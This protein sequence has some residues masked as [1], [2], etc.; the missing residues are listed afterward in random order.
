MINSKLSYL[1]FI[2]ALFLAELSYAGAKNDENIRQALAS[3]NLDQLI[4]VLNEIKSSVYQG[5]VLPLI[6]TLWKRDKVA[7]PNIHWDM[8]EYDIVRINLAD[9]LVQ[10]RNNGLID[11]EIDD[12]H[13][14]A[15]SMLDSKDSAVVSSA[16]MVLAQIDDKNDV[17]KI[18]KIALSRPGYLFRSSILSLSMMCNS[19]AALALEAIERNLTKSDE[20]T[21]LLETRAKFA[22]HKDAGTYCTHDKE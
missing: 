22:K 15:V 2:F 21:F 9:I 18:K 13:K 5:D 16:V 4:T 12:L 17:S 3:K 14:Y 11:T 20:K 6:Q 7:E 8:V 1:I 19:D 10:A